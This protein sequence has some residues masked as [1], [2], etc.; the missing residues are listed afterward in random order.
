M[1]N[2]RVNLVVPLAY[3]NDLQ[4]SVKLSIYEIIIRCE[5]VPHQPSSREKVSIY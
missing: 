3:C 4:F 5:T 2:A 1:P